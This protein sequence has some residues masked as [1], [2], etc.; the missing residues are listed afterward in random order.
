M[1][2]F[3]L[4]DLPD[5]FA[6][7]SFLWPLPDCKIL[8]VN[9][10]ILSRSQDKK[11]EKMSPMMQLVVDS[12]QVLSST[13][14]ID[15]HLNAGASGHRT[16]SVPAVQRALLILDFLAR[17]RRG[18]TI[19]QLTRALH[20]PKS[21]SHALLL[22]LERCG[23][24]QRDSH[25]GRYRLGSRLYGLANIALS[26]ISLREQAAPFLQRLA[27]QTRSTVHMAV[28]EEGEAVLIEK[29]APLGTLVPKISTWEGKRM[30]L[31]CTALGKAL[32]THVGESE[33]EKLVKKQGL[34]RHNENT[35]VS[36][37]KLKVQCDCI[38]QVGYSIDDEEEEIGVRCIGAPVFDG[39]RKVVAAISITGTIGQLAEISPFATMVK[40]AALALSA[41]MG[42]LGPDPSARDSVEQIRAS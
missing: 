12:V 2:Y 8:E 22:T 33:M 41:H 19:S 15:D 10:A 16:P 27:E 9:D 34:L 11:L 40:K 31:H 21:T 29:I 32:L 39:S 20:L 18:A 7:S 24:A 36:L 26:G 42:F 5:L 1:H 17:C 25:G 4:A 3:L 14:P 23:Y 35:V 37:S 38:R 13:M 6:D 30:G 28:L